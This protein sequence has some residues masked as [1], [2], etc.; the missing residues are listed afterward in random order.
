MN[1][2]DGFEVLTE[3][4]STV[5]V[6]EESQNGEL[7]SGA[8]QGGSTIDGEPLYI[9]RVTF[10]FNGNTYKVHG[11]MNPLTKG[12]SIDWYDDSIS[13]WT[14]KHFQTEYEILLKS[15]DE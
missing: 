9:G 10:D 6:W 15:T 4:F 7:P 2:Y 3:D 8:I 12:V 1:F 14:R 13:S 11:T 5:F